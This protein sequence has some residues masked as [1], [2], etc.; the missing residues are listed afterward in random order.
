[1]QLAPWLGEALVHDKRDS[2]QHRGFG[3]SGTVSGTESQFI[4][5][6]AFPEKDILEFL[7]P[8]LGT[9]AFFLGCRWTVKDNKN[10]GLIGFRPNPRP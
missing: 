2:N 9:T 10:K 6:F 3:F 8:L 5:S 4:L 1:M 7:L